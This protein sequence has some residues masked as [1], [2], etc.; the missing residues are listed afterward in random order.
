MGGLIQGIGN[1]FGGSANGS[2]FQAQGTNIAQPTTTDQAASAYNQAKGG[3]GQQQQLLNA[4]QGQN[5]IQNQSDV[6][7]QLQGVANGTGPNPAMAQL[8]QT[9]GQNVANQG[10]LMAGQRGA[11][12]NVGLEGRQIAQQGANTQQ[13][14]AGQAATLGAQQ[15]LGALGQLGGLATQ[16]VG[17]QTGA[18]NSFNQAAQGEQ[19]QLLNSINA[20]NNANVAMQSNINT[21]NAGVANNNANNS[22]N[23]IGGLMSGAAG[24][25]GL[26][27]GGKVEN[28]KLKNVSAS[29]RMDDHLY[30]SH[31]KEIGQLY[32]GNNFKTGGKVPGKAEV[33]G[34]SKKNDTV[35]AMLSPGE[36]VI[37][38]S[39]MESKDPVAGGA[40]MIADYQKKNGNS[41]NDKKMQGDFKEALKREMIR[42]RKLK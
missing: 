19:G 16:Q 25:V 3:I 15:Q 35:P 29:D 26:A 5:G 41:G 30:P 11:S 4:L 14:A 31:L 12:G 7:N 27:Q 32:H 2:G 17:Q 13:Q 42:G 9:T 33:K 40:K 6:Y 21:T 18:L 20:Q 10:A 34:D 37:P 36:F 38:K 1:L 28:P 39:I 24:L 22:S 23:A 8:N